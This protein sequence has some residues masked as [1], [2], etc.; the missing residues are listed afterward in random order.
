MLPYRRIMRSARPDPTNP[1]AHHARSIHSR[2]LDAYD[3]IVTEDES[4]VV[5]L[6]H[7]AQRA[8]YICVR[9]RIV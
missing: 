8:S 1:P 9:D 2:F 3:P 7:S 5:R 6:G 4:M